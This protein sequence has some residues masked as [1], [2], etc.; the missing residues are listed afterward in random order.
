MVGQKLQTRT[1]AGAVKVALVKDSFRHEALFYNGDDGFLRGTVPFVTEGLQA[2][3]PVL[4]A[5]R[6]ERA[7]LLKHALGGDAARVRFVDM[8]SLGRNPARIIPAWREFL[9][10]HAEGEAPVRGIGEPAWPG[11]SEAELVEGGGHE[12]LLN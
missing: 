1:P 9:A 11:R 10:E 6:D 4:V 5:V 3:E 7:Q 12:A 8:E 2:G